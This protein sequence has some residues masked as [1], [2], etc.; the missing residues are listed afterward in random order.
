M[1]A[2][3]RRPARYLRSASSRVESRP[4]EGQETCRLPADPTL[5]SRGG[6]ASRRRSVGWDRR[7]RL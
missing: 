2:A 5:A 3:A 4:V 1:A 7:R 6:G